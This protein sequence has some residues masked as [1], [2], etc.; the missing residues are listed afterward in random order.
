MLRRGLHH[1]IGR[2]EILVH[3]AH[4]DVPAF[5]LRSLQPRQIAHR[6][7]AALHVGRDRAYLEFAL[8][9]VDR[10]A[11][12]RNRPIPIGG[13]PDVVEPQ[14]TALIVFIDVWLVP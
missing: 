9:W 6:R 12:V 2:E 13:P 5:A 14:L 7:E 10:Y 3:R 11:R 8:E 1:R 4:V